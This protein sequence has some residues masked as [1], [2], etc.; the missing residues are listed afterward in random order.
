MSEC[1]GPDCTHSSHKEAHVPLEK[2][3]AW[4]NP[5]PPDPALAKEPVKKEQTVEAPPWAVFRRGEFFA[6]KGWNFNFLGYTPDFALV[7]KCEGMTAGE[8]KRRAAS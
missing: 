7:F 4:Q 3:V 2:A 5:C 6:M 8:R 1:S